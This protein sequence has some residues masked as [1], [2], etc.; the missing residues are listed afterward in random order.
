MSVTFIGLRNVARRTSINTNLR[1]VGHEYVNNKDVEANLANR[2]QGAR[3][4]S[5]HESEV[6]S[7]V[8]SSRDI[9]CGMKMQSTPAERHAEKGCDRKSGKSI[10]FTADLSEQ[11]ESISEKL[12]NKSTQ[13]ASDEKST[14]N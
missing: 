2:D 1:E 14:A 12:L 13:N 7:D 4:H 5:N 10:T 6:N 11:I 3:D 8:F 9:T